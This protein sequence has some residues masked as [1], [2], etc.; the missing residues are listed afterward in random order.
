MSDEAKV[1]HERSFNGAQLQRIEQ[2][3][4]AKIG[5]VITA[6]QLRKWAMEQALTQPSSSGKSAVQ[7]ATEI[8]DFVAKPALDFKVE[9]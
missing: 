2:A 9:P 4:Q 5:E 3:A 6:M 1:S 8:Y 7:T